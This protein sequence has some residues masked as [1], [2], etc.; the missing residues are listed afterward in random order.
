MVLQRCPA[1]LQA[2]SH[3]V[4]QSYSECKMEANQKM[5]LS[6][7]R[8]VLWVAQV[9][10]VPCLIHSSWLHGDQE[11]LYAK[12][13]LTPLAWLHFKTYFSW[14]NTIKEIIAGINY[15]WTEVK[16]RCKALKYD[17]N[18]ALWF[19]KTCHTRNIMHYR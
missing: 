13:K 3:K 12:I 17:G 8:Q 6:T 18:I 11:E 5:I 4:P 10:S 2:L 15:H 14:V 7:I 19:F 16:P 9:A 1:T